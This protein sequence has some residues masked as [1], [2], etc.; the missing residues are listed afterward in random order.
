MFTTPRK[1]VL[2]VLFSFEADTLEIGLYDW[3]DLVD[4]VF[5]VEATKTHKGATKPVM[6]ER[7]KYQERFKF[8]N[9]SKVVHVIVDDIIDSDKAKED[10]WYVEKLQTKQ[11]LKAVKTWSQHSG[12]LD[13]DDLFISA[14]IDEVMSR[15]ALHKLRWC[16][17]SSPIITGALWMPL[18]NL[19]RALRSDFP[20]TGSPH[21]YGLPTIYKWDTIASDLYDG[22]R[23]QVYY[24]YIAPTPT[25]DRYVAG[26]LHMTNTAFIPTA[27]LKEITATE[28]RGLLEYN[29][30]NTLTLEDLD[31]A[32]DDLY[33]LENKRFWLNQTD[34]SETVTDVEKYIP[35]LLDCNPARYPYWFGK[36]DPRNKDL[37]HALKHPTVKEK[38]KF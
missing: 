1:L 2:M 24:P 36:V 35:W 23:L 20:V 15:P 9:Q 32:Q 34:P 7:L 5:I 27:M 37:L 26:G 11:G 19:N 21:S 3:L 8:V 18:G 13:P 33:N 10:M 22:S 17:T 28:T 4:Y 16:Q 30:I 25:R 38:Y 12:K 14:D 31:V 6:W 29:F